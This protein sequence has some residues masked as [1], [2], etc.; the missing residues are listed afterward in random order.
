MKRIFLQELMSTDKKFKKLQK[1]EEKHHKNMLMK[2]QKK[3]RN[4]GNY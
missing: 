3:L 4:C 1:K 2:W